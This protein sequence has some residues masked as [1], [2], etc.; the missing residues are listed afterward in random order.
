MNIG[1]RTQ[2]YFVGFLIGVAI[3]SIL[4][5]SRRDR[6]SELLV[7]VYTWERTDASLEKLP[8]EIIHL[9]GAQGWVTGVEQYDSNGQPTGLKGY[10]FANAEGRR[11]WWYGTAGNMKLYD[12]EKF[13]A[14]SRPG[15]D[16]DTM[17]AGFEHQGHQVI[18]RRALAPDYLLQID[19]HSA[20]EMTDAYENLKSKSNYVASVGW[21]EINTLEDKGS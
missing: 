5:D 16:W 3:V 11:Y 7:P 10:F 6:G 2:A 13:T 15:L 19:V 18:S 4:L 14:T 21:L 17:K 1:K 9:T 8:L 20:V 12:G